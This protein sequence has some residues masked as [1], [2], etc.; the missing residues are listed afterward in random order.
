MRGC[1]DVDGRLAAVTNPPSITP[2]PFLLAEIRLALWDITP[3][4]H[5]IPVAEGVGTQ[6]RN[7]GLLIV[8]DPEGVPVAALDVES[9]AGSAVRGVLSAIDDVEPSGPFP[10]LRRTPAEA[11]F[12]GAAAIVGADPVDR[13]SLDAATTDPRRP[14]LFIV[15]DG[16]RVTPGPSAADVTRAAVALRD[17]LRREGRSADVI[18]VPAPDYGGQ[19]R[20]ADLADQI[21]AAYGAKRLAA[22]RTASRAALDPAEWPDASLQAWQ[23]WRPPRPQRG[24][25]LFFTGLSG[26]GKSTVA[27]AVA[28]HIVELGSR[29]VTLLDGDVVRRNLS[30]GL[31]FSRDDRDRNIERIGFVAAEI[32]RHGG[33]AVCAPIAPFAETRSKVRDMAGAAGDFVLV[34]V[35]TPLE[36]CERRDRKGLYARARRGEIPEF[37]G[38]SSPYEEP[39]DADV[40]I[41][42]SNLT[43]SEARD[44]VLTHLRTGGWLPDG[45]QIL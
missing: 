45:P 3:A 42:T 8:T 6:A 15:Y 44:V 9:V 4:E 20:A 2:D 31:G 23:S 26:S 11:S 18:V 28:E 21:A 10:T 43:I 36:E 19:D 24:L 37:T 1:A 12:D 35:A 16:P 22:E 27:R 17:E 13:F 30:A 7:A 14:V 34:H 33:L 41:D 5:T 38:I 40:V 32:A 39:D 25:V 29:T